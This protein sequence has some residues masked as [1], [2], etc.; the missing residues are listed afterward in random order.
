MSKL[1]AHFVK[2][3]NI[4]RNFNG[5]CDFTFAIH[6]YHHGDNFQLQFIRNLVILQL[7]NEDEKFPGFKRESL[8][9]EKSISG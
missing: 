9:P 6:S 2:M 8:V 7:K 4:F 1:K 3:V 5:M